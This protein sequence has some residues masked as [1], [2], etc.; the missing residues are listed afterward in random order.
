[1]E[2]FK[3]SKIIVIMLSIDS[4]YLKYI[5][6]RLFA[7]MVQNIQGT[8]MKLELL[9]ALIA[10]LFLV[11]V[12]YVFII[13]PHKTPWNAFILGM[14][15]YGIYDFTNKAIFRNYDWIPAVVDT[16]WGGILFYLVTTL[17]YK[18]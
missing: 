11:I 5:G 12:L 16:I 14:C 4:L 8:R 10:Y 6:S 9:S 13:Q 7:P 1:M 3:I 17:V 15:I 2:Y 18:L